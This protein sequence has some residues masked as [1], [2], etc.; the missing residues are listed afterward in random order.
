MCQAL[1][2]CGAR[3][4]MHSMVPEAAKCKRIKKMRENELPV[5]KNWQRVERESDN[6]PD[7]QEHEQAIQRNEFRGQLFAVWDRDP[8]H[9]LQFCGERQFGRA[10]LV[11]EPG[12]PE[13]PEIGNCLFVFFSFFFFFE[14][15]T[16]FHQLQFEWLCV[17]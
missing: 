2:Q 9:A 16:C 4:D 3:R 7:K 10:C 8:E 17:F 13:W 14:R 5:F 15:L 12:R 11:V 1:Y 6:S